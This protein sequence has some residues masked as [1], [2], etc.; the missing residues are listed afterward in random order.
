[1]KINIYLEI[2]EETKRLTME[3]LSYNEALKKAKEMY[4]NK[5]V[6]A[7]RTELEER[8]IKFNQNEIKNS[9]KKILEWE[10]FIEQERKYIAEC[11]KSNRVLLGR[12]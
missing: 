9:M 5:L 7:E 2:A 12:N 1:M 3:G 8:C 11:M 4:K 6:E 10:N